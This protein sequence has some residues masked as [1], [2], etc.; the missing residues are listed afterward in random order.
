MVFEV[1][2]RG[3][4][5]F[6]NFCDICFE[7]LFN[8]LS[9]DIHLCFNFFYYYYYYLTNLLKNMHLN[10]K[11]FKKEKKYLAYSR[12]QDSKIH[13]HYLEHKIQNKFIHLLTT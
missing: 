6:P 9:F 7:L 10:I 1:S 3:F 8:L 4:S 2:M 12:C 13:N 11:N 5:T